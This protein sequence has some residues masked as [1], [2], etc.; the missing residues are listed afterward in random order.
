VDPFAIF[1]GNWS[2]FAYADGHLAGHAWKDPGV[3]KAARDSGQGIESFY[4][5][6]GTVKN[7]DFVWMWNHY[8]HKDWKPL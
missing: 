3:I 7:P 2:T 8:R 5:A 1:H 4:W 6:G